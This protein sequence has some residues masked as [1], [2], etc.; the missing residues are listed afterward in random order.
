[1]LSPKSLHFV[2]LSRCN[3]PRALAADSEFR[4]RDSGRAAAAFRQSCTTKKFVGPELIGPS[5][6]QA[7]S[8]TFF[9][10][11]LFGPTPSS[12]WSPKRNSHL[13]KRIM[14]FAASEFPPAHP[15]GSH[16]HRR[17]WNWGRKSLR[18]WP[19]QEAPGKSEDVA[20][21][22]RECP[23]EINIK[24][25]DGAD[26][27]AVGLAGTAPQMIAEMAMPAAEARF[28]RKPRVS[29]K[30]SLLSFSQRQGFLSETLCREARKRQ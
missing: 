28:S 4:C 18:R 1:V 11:V 5:V 24:T 21:E 2:P 30:P 16:W 15:C 26:R 29:Q 19:V 6:F 9:G 25:K 13:D 20:I 14:G 7:L 3:T 27:P 8:S 22:R 23:A 17:I 10:T 12:Q